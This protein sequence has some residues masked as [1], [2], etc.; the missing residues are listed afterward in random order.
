MKKSDLFLLVCI[1]FICLSIANVISQASDSSI[2]DSTN[3]S[4][5]TETE[6]TII[7]IVPDTFKI[8]DVQLNI[9]IQ[10]NDNT[11]KTNLIALVSGRGYST[12]DIIGIDSLAP[13]A[14]D[15]I[16]VS[17]NFKENGNITLVIKIDNNLF[18]KTVIVLSQSQADIEEQARL[19]QEKKD[20]LANLSSQLSELK[21]KYSILETDYYAKQADN[22]DLSKVSLDQLKSYIRAID[23]SILNEDIQN[24]RINLNLAYQEYE[25]Q[26]TKLDSAT[27]KSLVTRLKDNAV[28]FSAIAGALL[29]FFALSEIIKRNG[30]HIAR[31]ITSKKKPAKKIKKKRRH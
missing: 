16:I 26:R 5:P 4:I 31:K 8:G 3:I 20:I 11:T 27:S 23:S 12:Y 30:E 24:S 18:Y 14:K 7:S 22:Y 17:G 2:N 13:N 21:K 29:A 19:E 9:R 28:I 10:N 1:L 25:D 15:Y 6:I